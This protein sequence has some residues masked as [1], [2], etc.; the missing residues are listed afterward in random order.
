M[1]HIVIAGATGFIGKILTRYFTSQ[2]TEVVVLSRRHQVDRDLVRFEKWDGKSLGAWVRCLE[3]AEALINLTGKSVDCRY[4]EK[5]KQDIYDSRIDA[6]YILGVAIQRCVKLPRLWI[7]AS[8]ATIYRHAEDREMDE[9]TGETGVG[10]SVDVCKKW[11][12][13]FFESGT[14]EIRKVALRI[15]ITLGKDGGAL[16]PM[17]KLVRLGLGGKQGSGKQYFSWVHESDVSGVVQWLIENDRASGV[18]N[19]SAPGP[20][21]NSGFMNALRAVL[22]VRMGVPLPKWMLTPGAWVINTEPELIL[23]SRRV[24]PA[25]L[26]HEG[27]QFRYTTVDLALRNI[28][29]N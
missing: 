25:R 6:T 5:N 11:E 23:K 14:P 18:Y 19:V 20:I 28:Y 4:N 12:R 22:K 24:V 17:C 2:G 13:V 29:E 9:T 15:A 8:S 21:K 27:Y 3:D 16:Q 1:K 10:F 7:N 26:I